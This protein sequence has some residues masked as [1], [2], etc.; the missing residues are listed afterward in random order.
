[1]CLLSG[2][3]FFLPTP[4]LGHSS[5]LPPPFAYCISSADDISAIKTNPKKP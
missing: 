3:Y 2:R 4:I 1:L 5:G